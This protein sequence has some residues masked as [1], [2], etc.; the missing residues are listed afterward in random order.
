VTA[1]TIRRPR[2]V[3]V[4]GAGLAGIRTIEQLR[5]GGYDGTLTLIGDEPHLPYDRPPLSKQ[6][7]LGTWER[8]Q[9]TLVDPTELKALDVELRLGSRAVSL[10]QDTVR[11]EDGTQIQADAIVLATGVVARRLP[12]QPD[13]VYTL[14]RLDDALRLRA[15]AEIASAARTLGK[16]VTV[17]EAASAPLV[18]VLG[19][20][21][22]RLAARLMTDAGVDLRLDCGVEAIVTDES[23]R[24]VIS[25]TDGNSVHAD[26]AVVGVGGVPDVE[27][28]SN[29][30]FDLGNGIACDRNGRA[31]GVPGVWALGDVA[32]WDHKSLGRRR[33][34]H[35]TSAADQAL[36]VAREIL[37][38]EP[39]RPPTPYVWSDQFGMR[40]QVLGH[41]EVADEIIEL[42]GT[43]WSSGPIKGTVLGYLAENRLVAVTGFGAPR[44]VVRYRELL[45]AE[46]DRA[47]AVRLA[48][49]LA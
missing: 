39:V 18:R 8:E 22:G 45:A 23:G 32:A 11:L 5:A 9:L 43:G 14:R 38:L 3:L 31:I 42:N 6:L 20:E 37:G 41:P 13:E 24:S 47:A 19:S 35:W 27:W 25:L 36:I 12:G 34:E 16:K 30:G 33:Y 28:L 49:S 10:E 2:H 44:R 7:L 46:G 21:A 48:A 1:P 40:I 4:V 15:G 17:V 26:I 29:S